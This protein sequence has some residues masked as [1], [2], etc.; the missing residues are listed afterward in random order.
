M[1]YLE[2][3]GFVVPVSAR[4]DP[5]IA[6]NEKGYRERGPKAGPRKRV[7][8]QHQ[9]WSFRTILQDE[10]DAK[11][12]RYFIS[13]Y[14]WNWDF[15]GEFYANRTQLGPEPGYVAEIHAGAGLNGDAAQLKS[16]ALSLS[17]D[18]GEPH[19]T[20]RWGVL[21]RIQHSD[22]SWHVYGVDDAGNQWQ[23]G[24][25]GSFAIIN[26]V[27]TVDSA[28]PVELRGY[29]ELGVADVYLDQLVVL[30]WRPV[31][32]MQEGWGADTAE[33]SP[34]THLRVSGDFSPDSPLIMVGEVKKGQYQM[35]PTDS[36][37]H[38]VEFRLT[39]VPYVS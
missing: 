13:G 17:F 36:G 23:D 11:A 2:F 8:K 12:L 19:A 21:F 5:E 26:N 37:A 38:L 32:E 3:N 31:D 35:K 9:A 4:S 27:L 6:R 30:P 33:F 25:S 39:E 34:L 28:G 16:G 24:V 29:D 22:N 18:I 20:G 14:G 7:R 1:A 10:V 15:N